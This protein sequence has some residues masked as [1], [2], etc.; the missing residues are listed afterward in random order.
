[1]AGPSVL[2]NFLPPAAAAS[3]QQL[4]G[5]D[6]APDC[7]RLQTLTV[8]QVVNK[9]PAFYGIRRFITVF[10]TARNLPL[11]QA[12]LVQSAP[13]I[14]KIYRN[15]IFTVTLRS[16]KWSFSFRFSNRNNVHI[17]VLRIHT[18]CPAHLKQLD[19]LTLIIS[20]E[21]YSR[22]SSLCSLLQFP[23]KYNLL[24]PNISLS[25]PLRFSNTLSQCLNL[26]R[27]DQVSHPHK[28]KGKFTICIFPVQD[29]PQFAERAI[30]NF[31]VSPRRT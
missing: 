31:R 14:F 6:N 21:Q 5:K 2:Q 4:S 23:A 30:S 8:P 19:L 25:T 18:T 12:I 17:S 29:T 13:I 20:A 22:S 28:T 24:D 10:T 26:K 1:V 3:F 27:E 9:F 16:S 7:S 11:S 15:V